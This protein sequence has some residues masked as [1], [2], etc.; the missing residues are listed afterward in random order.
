MNIAIVGYD[1][2]GRSAYEYFNRPE[3]TITICDQDFIT[4]TPSGVKTKFGGDYLNDLYT[5]DLI[6]RTPGLH[7]QAI[8]ENNQEDP[9]ILA[10]VTTVTNEFFKACPSKH[11]IGVTGTKGKGTTSTLITKLLETAGYR[12]HLGGNIGI[13]PLDLLKNDIKTDDWIVL[14]LANFQLIDLKYSP[15][16]AVCL[17]VAPEHLDWHQDM[18]EYIEAKRQMFAHQTIRDIAIFNALNNYSQ[19]VADASP[20]LQFGYEVPPEGVKPETKAGAYVEGSHIY[21]EDEKLCH[22]D[23]VILPGRHNLENVCAA[24]TATYPLLA[25]ASKHPHKVIKSVVKS[26]AGLPHR[27]ESLGQV[28]GIWFINDSFAVN[29]SSTIAAV[30]AIRQP[31]VLILGGFDRG[32]ELDELAQEIKQSPYVKKILVIGVSG[33]RLAESLQKHGITNYQLSTA[34]SMQTVVA[35]ATA[36]ARPGDAVV[37]SPAFPSF[38]M[39]KNFEDRGDQFRAAVKAL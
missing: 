2:Q 24:I 3:N 37:F 16:I 15:H 26:F 1:R 13:A 6:V 21:F 14:E 20:A 19:E 8:A 5:F 4:D 11:I 12:V 36:L 39:F 35:E 29:P 7:P 9:D 10:K 23:D 38:D 27:I 32:L 22:T 25:Q 34:T 18:Y 30:R 33:P 17:M 28:K 31:L